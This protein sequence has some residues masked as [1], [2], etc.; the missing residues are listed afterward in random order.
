[1]GD[2]M[3]I[4]GRGVV[5]FLLCNMLSERTTIPRSRCHLFPWNYARKDRYVFSRT[6]DGINYMTATILSWYILTCE[7]FI[8]SMYCWFYY[9]FW[10]I[11]CKRY[12]SHSVFNFYR[13]YFNTGMK[14]IRDKKK[15]TENIDESIISRSMINKY[16]NNT[17]SSSI[18]ILAP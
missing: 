17:L 16:E 12:V 9:T 7:R 18:I 4:R 13:V 8:I 10:E 11:G 6:N 2:K 15:T 5:S 3:L 14:K 1:M